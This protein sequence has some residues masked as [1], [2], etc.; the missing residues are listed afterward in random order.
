M[1]L[2]RSNKAL[3][4]VTGGQDSVGIRIPSHPVAQELLQLFGDGV[5]AP[6][7][8]KFGRLSPTS[9]EHV[10]LDLDDEVRLILDGGN[11]QVGIESTIVD[12]S[13]SCPQIL[14]PGMLD[15]ARIAEV[16]GLNSA[17]ELEKVDDAVRASGGLPSH[18]APRTPLRLLNADELASV[19]AG[20]SNNSDYKGSVAVLSF[21][22]ISLQT[23]NRICHWITAKADPFDYARALYKDLRRLDSSGADVILVEAPPD[24]LYWSAIGDRLMRAANLR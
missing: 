23:D 9:A 17:K 2:P 12:L 15:V 3:D 16:L 14:R 24:T 22:A 4:L 11:C 8:N 19:V 6:S 5:A 18:Y 10:R 7:A 13:S 20:K 1:I 21:Q